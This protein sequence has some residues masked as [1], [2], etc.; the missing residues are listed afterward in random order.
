M[1][2]KE[3]KKNQRLHTWILVLLLSSLF[4]GL[5]YLVSK[6]EGGIDLTRDNQ[7]TL[8]RETVAWLQKVDRPTDIIITIRQSNEQ[9]RIIQRLLLDL[10][11][12][13]NAFQSCDSVYPVNV[14]YININ[15][16]SKNKELIERYQLEDPNK[17]IVASYF[18]QVIRKKVLFN[19]KESPS[20]FA[21][22]SIQAYD[23]KESLARDAVINSN[24]YTDWKNGSRNALVP[25][26]FNGEE[27]ILQGILS[28]SREAKGPNTV[29]FTTGHGENDPSDVSR[30]NGYSQF[31]SVL[32]SHNLIVKKLSSDPNTLIPEDAAL[33]VIASPQVAF[34]KQEVSRLRS[35]MLE[36]NGNLLI[37]VDPVK[38]LLSDTPTAFGLRALLN[39]WNLRCHDMIINDP[40][41]SK[42]DL[43]TGDY[44]IRTFEKGNSHN[45]IKPINELGLSIFTGSMRP[46]EQEKSS[47][48]KVNVDNLFYSSKSSWAVGNW[49]NRKK[50]YKYDRNIDRSG[51]VPVA[52]LS[53]RIDNNMFNDTRNSGKLA[54]FG[55]S[56]FF[57]NRI[58]KEN[59]GNMMLLR[60]LIHWF[61]E[62]DELLKLKP[63]IRDYFT[64]KLSQE[65]F[66]KILLS[67]ISIP[68]A[69][70]ILGLVVKWLRLD[71]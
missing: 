24:F 30:E 58:L 27:V 63:R 68:F 3:A 61:S 7:F 67:L 37:L 35:F 47:L 65:Q 23:A 22:N 13:L 64:M 69:I 8:S 45:M 51:P 14:H 1:D 19:L 55:S 70:G 71:Y 62:E 33:V 6:I 49:L 16:L 10:K 17:I 12:L 42:F 46:V 4:L 53:E 28:V 18:G 44:S 60:N 52:A 66:E 25:T 26:T 48:I 43:F 36:R 50:P 2:F 39:D 29:Y 9:P 38:N 11:I 31:Q 57:T 32:E 20:T 21:K 5:N 56:K 41:I 59:A 34:R 54:V 40:D 15:P